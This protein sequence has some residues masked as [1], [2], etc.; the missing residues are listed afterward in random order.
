MNQRGIKKILVVDDE[1]SITNMLY[2]VL[3]GEGYE[4]ATAKDGREGLKVFESI[5]P[6]LVITDI[7]M[8]DMEGIE[9]TRRL[10]NKRK[11]LLIIVMSGNAVGTRFLKTARIFGARAALQK[12][13][14]IQELKGTLIKLVNS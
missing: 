2:L 8:P 13:F 6:D 4:V 1:S 3:T 7:V 14:T 11:G 5:K 12:P 10:V 9:F